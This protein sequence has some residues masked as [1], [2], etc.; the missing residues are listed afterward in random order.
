MAQPLH[1]YLGSGDALG[2]LREHSQR[3]RALQA[4]L[5]RLLP[6]KLAQACPVA[7][8]KGG[9]L[10][11]LARNGSI[12]SRMRQLLPTLQRQLG[13]QG[14][15]VSRIDVRVRPTAETPPPPP[16]KPRS[17]GHAG[18][19]SLTALEQSLPQQSEL[20]LALSRLIASARGSDESDK[21]P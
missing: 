15:L 9:T 12:A 8:F 17:I 3:L 13:E 5:E 11:L 4:L 21:Q 18:R 1:D 7:N 6:P 2:R 20:R 10:T 19:E 16:R 14:T